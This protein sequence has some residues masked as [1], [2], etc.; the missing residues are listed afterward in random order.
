[1]RANLA[2]EFEAATAHLDE[3]LVLD[4]VGSDRLSLGTTLSCYGFVRY[5][6]G[7]IE[8]AL[9][10][11]NEG[12]AVQEAA[13][14][15][16]EITA[17]LDNMGYACAAAGDTSAARAHFTRALNIAHDRRKLPMALDI[18]LG[19][20]ATLTQPDEAEQ[21][22][23]LMTFSGEH[24]S[25]WLE[26]RDRAA[27]WLCDRAATLPPDVFAA[28]QANGRSVDYEQAVKMVIGQ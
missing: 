9:A 10:M 15:S 24:P 7:E 23:A 11:L 13:E 19:W 22:V 4:R 25:A 2:G 5:L 26:T 14:A 28:A 17:V 18:T 3:A 16:L 6:A 27:R 21:A 12:L 8:P 20:T 1:M